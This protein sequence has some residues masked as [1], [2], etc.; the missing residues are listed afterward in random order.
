M[1]SLQ[2]EWAYNLTSQLEKQKEYFENKI[3]RL[4]LSFS[5]ESTE[6]RQKLLKK[7]EENKQL[8]VCK[9]YNKWHL[10]FCSFLLIISIIII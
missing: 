9:S 7:S 2:L 3:S 5:S 10:N 4:Q 1:D 6:L 8:Q